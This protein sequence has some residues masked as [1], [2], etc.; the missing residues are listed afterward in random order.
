[1]VN[2]LRRLAGRQASGLAPV[3]FRTQAAALSDVGLV[4]TTNEDRTLLAMQSGQ[5]AYRVRAVLG[6]GRVSAWSA[7]LA[8]G[9]EGG[10]P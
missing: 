3:V 1:M 9:T 8:V 5:L 7:A 2:W 6:P 4:R 10:P